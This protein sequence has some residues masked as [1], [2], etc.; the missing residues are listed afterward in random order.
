MASEGDAL[1]FHKTLPIGGA[2]IMVDLVEGLQ[3]PPEVCEQLKRNYVFS[4]SESGQEPPAQTVQGRTFTHRE[5]ADVLE[6][7]VDEL[8]EM[9]QDCIEHSGIHLTSY[10]HIYL[11]GG[12]IAMMNGGRVYLS[13]RLEQ[14]VRQAQNR[15]AKLKLPIYASTLGLADLVF[16]AQEA[17]GESQSV[18]ERIKDFF[19]QLL[20]R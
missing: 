19:A 15:S 11:T 5:V 20:Q 8:A 4:N 7:R 12:G 10:S 18:I 3:A 9:I 2:H 16:E 6:P 14:T 1:I 17:P 13:A